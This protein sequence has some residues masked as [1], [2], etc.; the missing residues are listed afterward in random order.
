[1]GEVKG[2][3]VTCDRCGTETFLKFVTHVEMD[4]GFSPGYDKYEALPDD[5]LYE[6]EFGHLCPVCA[7]EFI[8]FIDNFMNGKVPDKWKIKLEVRNG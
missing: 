3:R 6:S 5:W 8:Y 1:M 2:K 4:G 7:R